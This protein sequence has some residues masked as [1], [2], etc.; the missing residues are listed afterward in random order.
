MA[1]VMVT[2]LCAVLGWHRAPRE[3][4]FDGCSPSGRCSRCG[5]RVLCDS[6]GNWFGT[7][8]EDRPHE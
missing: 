4:G 5:R 2:L 8:P 6:Q 7:D 1:K 3:A